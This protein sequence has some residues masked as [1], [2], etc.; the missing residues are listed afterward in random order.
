MLAHQQLSPTLDNNQLLSLVRSAQNK[1]TAPTLSYN[2]NIR[3]M[4]EEEE[5][6][7]WESASDL[8]ADENLLS[9]WTTGI[10]HYGPEQLFFCKTE[11]LPSDIL[12][13]T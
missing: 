1:S 11:G 5:D 3:K 4:P 8:S 13:T 6:R 7:D 12:D 2:E 10:C 9:S